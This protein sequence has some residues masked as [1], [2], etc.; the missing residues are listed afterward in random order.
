MILL[1]MTGARIL[2]EVLIEQ[3]VR[4]VFGYP[5]GQAINIYDQLYLCRDPLTL[6]EEGGNRSSSSLGTATL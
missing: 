5:G 6:R 4:D 3:G 2:V 1:K